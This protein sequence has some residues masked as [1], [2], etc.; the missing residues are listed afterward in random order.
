MIRICLLSTPPYTVGPDV[1]GYANTFKV[2]EFNGQDVVTIITD[3]SE[4]EY[5]AA[6]D[7]YLGPEESM[8]TD[9]PEITITPVNLAGEEELL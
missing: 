3:D 8:P 1:K 9:H 4:S 2:G 5:L 6:C 7:G